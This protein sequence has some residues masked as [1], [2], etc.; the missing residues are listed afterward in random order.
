M[1][2]GWPHVRRYTLYRDSLLFAQT[3]TPFLGP[4]YLAIIPLMQQSTGLLVGYNDHLVMAFPGG[5]FINTQVL[6]KDLLSTRQT[7][8]TTRH[9]I[10][11]IAFQLSF[12]SRDTAS[13]EVSF[14]QSITNASKRNVKPE[15]GFFQG[16]ETVTIPRSSQFT[17]GT[18][19]SRMVLY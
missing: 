11:S 16:T 12:I 5:R 19:T 6:H 8:S 2:E 18:P 3:I 14:N 7:R 15:P 1:G 13:T 17:L 4:L 10:S 9:M